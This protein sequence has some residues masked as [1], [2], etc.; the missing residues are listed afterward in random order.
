MES[1]LSLLQHTIVAGNG[2][3][4][5]SLLTVGTLFALRYS[6]IDER[7]STEPTEDADKGNELKKK[8]HD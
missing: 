2:V 6:T 5:I 8:I 4:I 3:E 7:W 1:I